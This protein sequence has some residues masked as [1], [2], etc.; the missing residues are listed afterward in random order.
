MANVIG[1]QKQ[2]DI[3]KQQHEA[4]KRLHKDAQAQVLGI[5]G[6]QHIGQQG[7]IKGLHDEEE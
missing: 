4:D 2:I 3:L 1:T 6:T 7:Y 5:E